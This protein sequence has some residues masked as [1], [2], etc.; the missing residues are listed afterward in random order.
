MDNDDLKG[1]QGPVFATLPRS[2]GE[3]LRVALS[4]LSGRS[5]LD[6]RIWYPAE[7][8]TMRPSKKG[9]TCRLDQLPELEAALASASEF[10]RRDGRLTQ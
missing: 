2:R 6:L 8:G 7:D 3:E 4:S 5:F 9:V 10:A 1:T